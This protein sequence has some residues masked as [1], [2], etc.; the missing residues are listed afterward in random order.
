MESMIKKLREI[1]NKAQESLFSTGNFDNELAELKQSDI[2]VS[3]IKKYRSNNPELSYIY[4]KLKEKKLLASFGIIKLIN[5]KKNQEL[6]KTNSLEQE[7]DKFLK[8]T[9][10]YTAYSSPSCVENISGIDSKFKSNDDIKKLSL[11]QGARVS[12][13]QY[14]KNLTKIRRLETKYYYAENY[15]SDS[16]FTDKSNYEL[17]LKKFK[18]L[19]TCVENEDLIEEAYE[20]YYIK[21]EKPYSLT[22]CLNKARI[23]T[24]MWSTVAN[25]SIA[26]G[27]YKYL[28]L[29]LS[30]Y[31]GLT[32]TADI[33]LFLNCFSISLN[34]PAEMINN[35]PL[36]YIKDAIDAG[37]HYDNIIYYLRPKLSDEL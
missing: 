28:A 33:E 36:T 26:L 7:I 5:F 37:L 14:I 34:S 29:V 35:V 31:L 1:N 17:P 22:R 12:Q 8:W 18:E 24:K 9:P 3:A 2:S 23:N 20:Q 4:D 6:K 21:T 16:N 10:N 13:M 25:G 15:F 19:I 27:N 30:F 11:L 32:T